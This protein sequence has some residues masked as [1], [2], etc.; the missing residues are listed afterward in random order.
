[1]AKKKA[2]PMTEAEFVERLAENL[3]EFEYVGGVRGARMWLKEFKRTVAE[4]VAAGERVSL[5]KLV[6]FEPK[7][8]PAK[9]KGEMVRNPRTGETV[10]RAETVPASF[11]VK[12]SASPA[13]KKEF[14]KTTTKA[15]KDLAARLSK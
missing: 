6:K 10:P 13:L 14:P 8:V 11:K 9:M 5:T 3:G 15:G 4:C 2:K 1:M 12:A 7:Y